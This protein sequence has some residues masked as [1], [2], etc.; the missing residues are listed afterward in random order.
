[1]VSTSSRRPQS[2]VFEEMTS[3]F[4]LPDIT[5]HKN[6]A[7]ACNGD[8]KHDRKT[9]TFCG[10]DDYNAP[11][12]VPVTERD[13]DETQATVR[14]SQSPPIALATVL[15]QM[16]DE[17]THLKIQLAAY[18]RV[19]NSHDPAIGRKKRKAVRAKID[20]L[21]AE[22]EKRSEQIYALYDVL[23]GQKQKK[24]DAQTGA[25]VG[26]ETVEETLQGL[27]IDPVELAQRAARASTQSL[28]K[29]SK[30]P[31]GMK[32]LDELLGDGDDD[33]AAWDSLSD[34]SDAESAD[35]GVQ[36]SR[37]SVVA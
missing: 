14:P 8:I 23:E 9:C 6:P 35:L 29:A 17:V 15:K 11:D 25:E 26:D 28:K 30:K 4:I 21:L 22:I 36:R 19:Y 7:T 5:L 2:T 3:G 33:A 32:E 31:T 13:I 18:E 12:P 34:G 24:D 20:T 10:D 16:Q 37:G 27:G 1:M